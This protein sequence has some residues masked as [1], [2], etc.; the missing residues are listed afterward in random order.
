MKLSYVIESIVVVAFGLGFARWHIQDPNYSS[1]YAQ[2]IW[3]LWLKEAGNGFFAGAAMAGF[4]GLL[5]EVASRRSPRPW[6]LGRWAWSVVGL[7]LVSRHAI[8]TT[9]IA[10]LYW[11]RGYTLASFVEQLL[12]EARVNFSNLLFAI[13]PYIVI[14]VGVTHWVCAGN[15]GNATPS[16]GREWAGRVFAGSPHRPLSSVVDGFFTVGH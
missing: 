4:L 15:E 6:G 14:A 11:S 2:L 12:P 10:K 5:I 7:F 9:H 3:A 13:V 8:E 16:D 1:G